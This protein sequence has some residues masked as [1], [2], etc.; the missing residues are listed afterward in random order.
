VVRKLPKLD[1]GAAKKSLKPQGSY[2]D[3]E[4]FVAFT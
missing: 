4:D 3:E 2:L 1:K